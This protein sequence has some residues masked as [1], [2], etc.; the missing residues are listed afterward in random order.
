[1]IVACAMFMAQLDGAVVVLALPQ[2]ARSFG[3]TPVQLTIGITAYLLAQII[4]LPTGNWFAGRFGG[5][6]VFVWAIVLFTVASILCALSRT[7]ETFVAARVLQG[8]AAAFMAPVGRI[9]MLE[10]TEKRD[11]VRVMTISTV[12]MLVAPTLGPALGGLITT[13]LSWQWIF[14]L[15]VPFGVACATFALRLMRSTGRTSDSPFDIT[16]FLLFAGGITCLL[17]ALQR[18]G[19]E[20]PSWHSSAAI[21]AP[22]A[23]LLMLGWR[24]AKVHAHPIVSLNALTVAS[25]SIGAIRGGALVRLPVRSLSFLLPLMFQ[26]ALG[27]TAVKAGMLMLALNGGDLSMKVITAPALRRFGFRTILLATTF[28]SSASIASC[29]L[30]ADET[31]YFVIVGVLLLSGMFR[32]LLFTGLGTLVFADIPRA[33]IGSASILWNIVQQG[34]NVL[35]VS[36]SAIFLAI[37]AQLTATARAQP[38]LQ[39]FRLA[40]LAM[41]VIGLTSMLSLRRLAHDAGA[42]VSDHKPR[43]AADRDALD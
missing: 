41:A 23:V 28:L 42:T 3:T 43:G 40:L 7:L 11:L 24:H 21:L 15:N 16:G 8:C 13:Y 35:G 9:V 18:L 19:D 17:Y 22:G 33:E 20:Y 26:T 37:G 14:L 25:F 1:M 4:L 2:I 32:S 39:D 29:A 10:S 34:T 5:R 31:P 12:P 6:H 30:F 27:M 36:L 38:T